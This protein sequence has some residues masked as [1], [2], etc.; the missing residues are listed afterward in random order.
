[1]AEALGEKRA[2]LEK[3][4]DAAMG[5][6]TMPERCE[7]YRKVIPFDRIKALV[8]STQGG[9]VN[10]DS[11]VR[12]EEGRITEPSEEKLKALEDACAPAWFN[13]AGQ[14]DE[15][16]MAD[17]LA[18]LKAIRGSWTY[19]AGVQKGG[20]DYKAAAAENGEAPANAANILHEMPKSGH[21]VS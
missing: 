20:E 6:N 1:M 2:A 11:P 7:A 5:F 19:E 4:I 15:G 17:F 12:K 3:A 8:D 9:S 13:D 21:G 16:A 14:L 10:P 18:N